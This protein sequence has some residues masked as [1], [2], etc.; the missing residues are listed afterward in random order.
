MARKEIDENRLL[1]EALKEFTGHSYEEASVNR[2]ISNAGIAKGSFYYRFQNKY[3]LYLF[4]LREASSQKWKFIKAET[5]DDST[6][7]DIFELFLK[8]AESGVRFA[9]VHPGYHKLGIML[10]REKGTELYNQVLKDLDAAEESGLSSLIAQYYESGC[11]R[12]N[13]SPEF[14][15]KVMSSLFASF[16]DIFFRD[17]EHG[18]KQSI[19]FLKDFV[20]FMKHGLKAD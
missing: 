2:I 12:K 4:L 1:E 18:L 9:A 14:I 3:E 20:E 11:F 8:Q 6:A 7:R 17:E 13:F 10:S 5:G 16:D 19:D 15:Q